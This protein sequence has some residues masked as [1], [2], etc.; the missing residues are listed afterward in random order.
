[1]GTGFK[2]DKCPVCGKNFIIP[3]ETV[4]K[5]KTPHDTKYYCSYSCF[6]KGEPKVK[7]KRSTEVWG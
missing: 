2:E 1:M 3:I 5:R 4:Y 6:R 7:K